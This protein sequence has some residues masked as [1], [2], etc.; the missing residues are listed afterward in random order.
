LLHQDDTT[1]SRPATAAP[2]A[3]FLCR[4]ERSAGTS[5]HVA[6]GA[7]QRIGGDT[8]WYYGD[9]LFALRGLLDRMAGGIGMRRGRRHPVDLAVGD[10]VDCWRVEALEPGARLRL[11][12]EMRLPGRGWLEW[13]VI[14]AEDGCTI[15]QTAL[16]DPSGV[17][18]VVYWYA[19]LP[20]HG[21]LFEGMVRS[22]A[23]AVESDPVTG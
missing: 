17:L 14:E 19:L 12:G 10:S 22:I 3:R 20:I 5:A 13:E 11:A 18:G 23:R 15:R 2:I 16:F 8:G 4:R 6:F 21:V 7:I 1:E 9:A